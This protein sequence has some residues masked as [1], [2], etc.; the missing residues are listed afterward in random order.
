[1]K[2][3]EI[4]NYLNEQLILDIKAENNQENV[5]EFH[6]TE[7]NSTYKYNK[8]EFNLKVNFNHIFYHKIDGVNLFNKP[9]PKLKKKFPFLDFTK[10]AWLNEKIQR[11][12][13]I[14]NIKYKVEDNDIVI[15]SDL[16]EIIDFNFFPEIKDLVKKKEIITIKF[17]QTMYYFNL[18]D[19]NNNSGPKDWS[20]RTFIM[21]GKYFKQI[22]SIDKLRIQ[23]ASNQLINKIYCPEAIMGF[24]HTWLL[25]SDLKYKLSNYSHSIKDHKML[26]N[27]KKNIDNKTLLNI[28]NAKKNIIEG[29]VL[30]K[31]SQ[32]KL[33]DLV[34]NKRKKMKYLF[35]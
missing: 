1:M 34:E 29:N 20:Y 5:D 27:Y 14:D 4:S 22:K 6:V 17:Y 8:K 15:Y 24:H 16:D 18:F 2:I 3:Y 13:L 25:S 10:Y 32:I 19:F 26:K 33:L 23:G 11:D 35:V 9:F 30:T 31:N 7:S 21:T 12:F 28:V